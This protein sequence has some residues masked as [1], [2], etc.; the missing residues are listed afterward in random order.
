MTRIGIYGGTFN[1]IHEGHLKAAR[2][3][4]RTLELERV[5]FVPSAQPPHKSARVRDPIAPASDRMAWVEAAIED[6]SRFEASEIELVR[7]GTSYTIDTLDALVEELAPARLVFI[8]GQ[9]AFV[10]MGTWRAPREILSLVDVAV[11]AR[12]PVEAGSLNEWLPAF[13][14]QSVSIAADGRSAHNREGGTRIE[15]LEI[16]A[17]DISASQIR[18]DLAQGRAV[19]GRLPASILA[20]V[21]KSGYYSGVDEAVKLSE[22]PAAVI[23]EAQRHKLELIV[24]AALERNAQETIALDV[25]D[26]T[27]YTDCVVVMSGNSQR[28]LR[29]IT[30]SIVK[31]L[32]HAGDAPL[33]VEGGSDATWMLID[34][35]DL[36]IHVFQPETREFFD[37]EGLWIDAPRVQLDH[38]E[39]APS[40]HEAWV[41]PRNA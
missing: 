34:A 20:R 6:E 22:S 3:A 25:R 30:E 14:Q 8:I 41:P 16:G 9:D 10:E 24:E 29:A 38:P 4:A 1:P 13:A 26:L 23:D 33:G 28:Q 18:E 11:V 27:S 21:V 36:I 19:D 15:V 31:A 39:L 17:L 32:K 7:E 37:I 35:N 12:P 40:E 2:E 5:I